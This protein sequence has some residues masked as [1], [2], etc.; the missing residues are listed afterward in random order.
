MLAATS[1]GAVWS[2]CSPDFGVSGVLDRFYQISPKILFMAD[3]YYYNGRRFD[4]LEKVDALGSDPMMGPVTGHIAATPWRV[5]KPNT[6]LYIC[7]LVGQGTAPTWIRGAVV[8]WCRHSHPQTDSN[9]LDNKKRQKLL[10]TVDAHHCTS[11]WMIIKILARLAEVARKSIK[12]LVIDKRSQK[13][14]VS[15]F[16]S[17][18]SSSSSSASFSKKKEGKK[19]GTYHKNEMKIV[20]PLRRWVPKSKYEPRSAVDV[21]VLPSFNGDDDVDEENGVQYYLKMALPC[22]VL[23][24]TSQ[25]R[26]LTA[27][28]W[29]GPLRADI[30]W[31]PDILFHSTAEC[32]DPSIFIHA[33]VVAIRIL[34]PL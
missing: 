19:G 16:S 20:F 21:V 5:S 1:L 13:R 28:P 27:V 11:W 24:Y 10:I 32:G 2:S 15:S 14:R 7:G 8:M 34:G 12:N 9:A 26:R 29:G 23:R 3:G 18:S 4:C 31:R 6:S 25:A 30:L 33:L 22:N 17:S